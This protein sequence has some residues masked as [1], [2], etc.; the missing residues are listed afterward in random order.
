LLYDKETDSVLL[1]FAN[2]T[3]ASIE[4]IVAPELRLIRDAETAAP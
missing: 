3:P 4:N 1:V 2:R